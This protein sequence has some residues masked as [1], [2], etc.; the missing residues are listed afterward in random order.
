VRADKGV[1]CIYVEMHAEG[2]QKLDALS[3][4]GTLNLEHY[5]TKDDAH[6]RSLEGAVG[7]GGVSHLRQ[8]AIC[9]KPPVLTPKRR[10]VTIRLPWAHVFLYVLRPARNTL[11]DNNEL[12]IE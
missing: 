4:S 7:A 2:T 12:V 10:K 3:C 9:R 11:T 8:L 1:A 6:L 5:L